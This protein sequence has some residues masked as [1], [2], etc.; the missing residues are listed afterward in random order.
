MLNENDLSNYF[1]TDVVNTICHVHD[2]TLIKPILKLTPY[3]LF[4]EENPIIIILIF[5][6][7]GKCFV[8]N[9]DKE[10]WLD[11]PKSSPNES[12][13]EINKSM[14]KIYLQVRKVNN[15]NKDKNEGFNL[16]N[17]KHKINY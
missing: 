3:E 15:N 13:S 17:S 1:W 4:K 7:C 10:K 16:F 2:R 5:F 9:N 12:N 14:F 11:Y 8:L 6:F